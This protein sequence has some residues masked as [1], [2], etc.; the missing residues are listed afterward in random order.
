MPITIFDFGS[1]VFENRNVTIIGLGSTTPFVINNLNEFAQLVQMRITK[2]TSSR[3]FN[4]VT[5][6]VVYS[7]KA[8]SHLLFLQQIVIQQVGC[9]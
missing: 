4:G 1:L 3:I 8:V 6:D 5:V 2:G 9:S 7:K